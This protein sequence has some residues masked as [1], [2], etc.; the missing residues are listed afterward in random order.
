MKNP[1]IIW[2]S[3]SKLYPV[4]GDAREIPP[5]IRVR[6]DLPKA[7]REFVLEH[8]KYH[9]KDWQRLRAKKI[10]EYNWIWGEIKAGFYGA[11]KHPFGFL[12]CF[13]MLSPARLKFYLQRIKKGN[14]QGGS[15]L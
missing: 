5:R 9:I 2:V 14:R 10:K 1:K 13:L 4:L 8:E 7:V 12:L 6:K 11:K 3:K 15:L